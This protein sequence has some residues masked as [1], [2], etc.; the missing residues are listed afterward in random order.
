MKKTLV[1]QT[2]AAAISGLALVGGVNAA[3]LGPTPGAETTAANTRTGTGPATQ[4]QVNTD[5]IG[6]IVVVP[7]YTVQNGNDTYVNIV[8]SDTRNAKAV[9]VRFRGASNS[10]DV[11]DFTVL[12]SPGDVFAFAVTK[13]ADG[14]PKLN[15][16]DNSCTLPAN[17]KQ[18]FV[19]S[20]LNA[21]LTAA[22]KAEQASEGYI[23]ILNMADIPPG[24][25]YNA[26]DPTTFTLF[27]MIKHVGGTPRNCAASSVTAL[28][29]DPTTY[30]GA[31][32]TGLDV[33]TSGLMANW[34]IIN[35]ARS[36]SYTGSATAVEA[37]QDP[38]APAYDGLPGWGNIVFSP[39]AATAVSTA[40]ARAWTTDPLLRGAVADNTATTFAALTI[41]NPAVSPAQYDF[42]DLSTPYLNAFLG[43]GNVLPTGENG[44]RTKGQAW[45]LTRA[46]AVNS[47]TNEFTTDLGLKAKT[48]WVFSMPTRRYNVAR[49]Y[50]GGTPAG[51]GAT[52]YTDLRNLDGQA[53]VVTPITTTLNTVAINQYNFFEPLVAAAGTG[54]VTTVSGQICVAGIT[55]AGGPTTAGSGNRFGAV[56]ADRE[57]R[58]VAVSTEFVISP[59]QPAD[60]LTFCGETSVLSFN[61]AGQASVLGATVAR[62]DLTVAYENG[63]VR[64]ATPGLAGNNT[65]TGFAGLPIV[66]SAMMLLNNGAAAPGIAATYG[67][68][69]QHR[70]TRP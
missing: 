29:N 3:V 2:V 13:G 57:E 54:N 58:F 60:P 47:I 8:N 5:G 12:M 59:G 42:P 48:D 28:A 46:F 36:S 51:T 20:R 32:T 68:T 19:T 44:L 35:V 7:Y 15:H 65:A 31:L 38:V 16:G 49:D 14:L 52:V 23:E 4:F 50:A 33:P 6:H 25:A 9:K 11:F 69:F 30:A 61:A 53:G 56:T 45:I 27:N 67:Q 64:L 39:Q 63:W 22:Q 70:A 24:V 26:T 40:N 34:T 55:V 18:S 43:G 37:R 17:V 21:A 10:D 62:K 66:G 41:G 1:A